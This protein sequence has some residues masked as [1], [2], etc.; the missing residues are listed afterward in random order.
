MSVKK[1][2]FSALS[3]V[4]TFGILL[5]AFSLQ[6]QD[7]AALRGRVLDPTRMPLVGAAVTAD[8]VGQSSPSISGVSDASGTFALRVA[9]GKYR[10]TVT[11][12]G[13]R[14]N[15]SERTVTGAN[16]KEEDIVLQV[17]DIN[18]S[19]TVTES[20]YRIDDTIS[21]TKTRTPLLDTP[22]SITVITRELMR[23][24]LM[25]TIGDA[26]RYVPGI[27]THQGENNRDQV[28]IRGNSTSADFYVNGVRDDVQY[29][30]DLYALDRMEA[31]KGPNAMAFGRGG[32]G[33]VINRV[34]KEP[35]S[36]PLGEISLQG[37]SFGDKRVTGDFNHPLG[38][39]FAFR[40]NAMWEDSNTFR[41]NVGFNRY[42]VTPTLLITP[43]SK[44]RIVL[45]Y[46]RFHDWRTADRGISSF[47]GLPLDIPVQTYF[48][49]PKTTYVK[50][51]VNTG[52]ALVEHQFGFLN[53]RNRS[54]FAGYDRGYSNWVPGV[55]TAD[56][57]FVSISGYD[58]AT[59]RL[60]LFNQTDLT[61]TRPT[62]AVRHTLLGGFEI[63]RQYT[64]N[65]R[66]T[67]FINNTATTISLP[68]S[69]PQADIATT[70]R[71]SATDAN[72]HLKTILGAG[73]VQDQIEI[74]R[75]FRIIGGI[76][77]DR[78]NL[79][80]LNNR[81]LTSLTRI[82]NLWSPRIGLLFKPIASVSVYGNYN[83]SWLPSSGDQFSSL[84]TIT[85][86][87]KPEKFTNYEAGLKWDI[88]RSF[89]FTTAIY[90]LDRTNTRSTDPNDATRI[91]QTGSTR[92]NGYEAGVN[93]SIMRKWRVAGGYSYQ[94]A[95]I[96][97]A[98]AAARQGAQVA[99]V[100]HHT[101]SLWNNY[102]FIS[103]LGAG[104]GI[105]NRSDM[106]VAVDNTV[107]M[108]GYTRVDG[109]VFLQLTEKI[110]LQGNVENIGNI[111]YYI[112]ADSNTNI[113]PGS[114]RAAKI[115]LTARF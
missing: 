14:K 69:N 15:D 60:N 21:A 65:F 112:N 113:S 2:T 33:G 78:F 105:I 86:Q 50:A 37:G 110:R 27:Q 7:P 11:K 101:F 88:H 56:R 82:D 22:Q 59:N 77:F 41:N 67:A 84:T 28:I 100:P 76:R 74:T 57:Q 79:N 44:T 73:Y 34:T 115:A 108:P 49:D 47:Q 36:T 111:K 71:Q 18:E 31:L 9:P 39:K 13:F 90:R 68:V 42:G 29:Y 48:G 62:G 3:R 17:A 25:S 109:A 24:Q 52:S 58:N 32:G 30:R 98:T 16:D 102:Q 94:D 45:S 66:N 19:V 54:Q 10:I 35:L 40:G 114:T 104:L 43:G 103:R 93:G 97:N 89:S 99:Q 72:N 6:A 38:E 81:D 55:V 80:Y 64:D 83:V 70:F 85:Q 26:V 12:D 96:S 4:L 106:W 53:I 87:V 95:F 91:I 63:G 107:K 51:D 23:D 1:S 46:E 61:Y 8:A 92:T 20:L 75:Y 5:S